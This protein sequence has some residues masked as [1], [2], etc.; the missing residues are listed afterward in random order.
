MADADRYHRLQLWLGLLGFG[1]SLA[2]LVALLL[3]GTGHAVALWAARMTPAAW[4]QVALVTL[5][6]GLGHGALGTPVTLARGFWLPR[7]YGLLHQPLRAWLADR[8]KAL[9]IGGT[10]SLAAVEIVY[11]LIALTPYWWLVAAGIFFVV[12]IALTAVV[13]IWIVPLFYPLSPLADAELRER[14]L[15][16]ARRARVEAVGV[17]VA[18]Q[19]RKSRTA[20]AAVV[21]IGRTRRIIV[22]DTLLSGFTPEEIESVLAHELGHHVHGDIRRGLLVHGVLLL[23]T[24]RLA[25]LGL[26]VGVPLLGL[27]GPADPAGLPWL[28][29]VLLAL[30]LIQLPLGNGFSRWI[31]RQADDFALATTGN[32][33]AFI[34]AMERLALLNLAERRPNRL[35]EIVFYSHP[36][37]ERRIERA[38]ARAA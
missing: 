21:G 12:Q 3:T 34:G 38:R 7:R 5:A 8:L 23:V 6:L 32:A 13:P 33:R 9:L 10:L 26:D 36:A 4:A 14:L 19:S 1:I 2:Y 24:A 25:A 29:L 37:L 31:E 22:F 16:L 30:G 18:D 27:T 11:G 20:N 35:K 15:A 17:F 28:G